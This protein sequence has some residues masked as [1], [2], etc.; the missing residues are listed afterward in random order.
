MK[1][2]FNTDMT[3]NTNSAPVNSLTIAFVSLSG[4]PT[5]LYK[6]FHFIRIFMSVQYVVDHH[7]QILV[8][9]RTLRP[10]QDRRHCRLSGFSG[11]RPAL[12]GRR[13]I[14]GSGNCG[15]Y[16][17]SQECVSSGASLLTNSTKGLQT[18]RPAKFGPKRQ[19]P[20]KRKSY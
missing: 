3:F 2:D 5:I 9:V 6:K 15:S 11:T 18:L 4:R 13:R 17:L 14:R 8:R 12:I 10:S 7:N 16:G 20:F 1:V 19:N